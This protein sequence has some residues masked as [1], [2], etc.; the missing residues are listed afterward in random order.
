MVHV[1][2]MEGFLLSHWALNQE[3]SVLGR[4]NPR[5]RGQE[6]QQR[7]QELRAVITS[8]LDMCHSYGENSRAG[9]PLVGSPKRAQMCPMR[10][11]LWLIILH[12]LY[13][14]FLFSSSSL[15]T[16]FTQGE[17]AVQAGA[18]AGRKEETEITLW[19][20]SP[21]PMVK[22]EPWEGVKLWNERLTS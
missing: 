6:V 11:L 4:Q 20:Q 19:L 21:H 22:S 16:T 8:Q 12:L 13:K 9:G 3:R 7:G 1:P 5:E 14:T 15:S 18:G 17:P 2:A 10:A